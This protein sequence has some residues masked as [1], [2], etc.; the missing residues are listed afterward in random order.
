MRRYLL[1]LIK[2]MAM[3]AGDVVPGVSG[4]TIAF[5]TGIYEEL[6]DSIKSID[7]HALKTLWQRGPLAAWRQINGNFLLAV[8]GGVLISVISLARL[9]EQAMEHNPI[10]IWSFFFGLVCASA[11]Y[12]GRQ[13]DRW[14]WVEIAALVAGIVAA[15]AI[16]LVKPAQLPD[17]WWVITLAGAV[18]ICAMI[19]PGISGAFILVLLGLYPTVLEAITG[20][21]IGLLA[22]FALGCGLGLLGFSRLLSWLLHHYHSATLATLT[23]FLLGSL[24]LLW[25]WKQTLETYRDRHGELVPLV[26]KNVSA[27]EYAALLG[28]DSQWLLACVAMAVGV[29]LVLGMEYL[30][31]KPSAT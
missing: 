16:G 25:P 4:G 21:D 31:R 30:A 9:I 26:Q 27:T 6:I 28:R 22:A 7:H 17:Y 11:V 24:N 14:R 12:V 20:V 29:I 2:G 18:A 15:L 23:G 5:I 8:F 19:L 10:L 13:I 1:L 3:G